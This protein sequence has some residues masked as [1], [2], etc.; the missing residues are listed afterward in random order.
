MLTS[1]ACIDRA[2]F[3][4]STVGLLRD[5]DPFEQPS[6]VLIGPFPINKLSSLGLQIVAFKDEARTGATASPNVVEAR[7]W[8][9]AFNARDTASADAKLGLRQQVRAAA[10]AAEAPATN[11]AAP[12]PTA[13]AST[14]ASPAVSKPYTNKNRYGFLS[15]ARH[16]ARRGGG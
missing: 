7:A 16:F 9:A 5:Q 4:D 11:G 13:T 3:T 15:G 12:A 2:L 1:K 10:G 6:C 8:I 14:A